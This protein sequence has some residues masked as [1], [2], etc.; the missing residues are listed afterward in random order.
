MNFWRLINKKS[1]HFNSIPSPPEI[2]LKVSSSFG[3][4]VPI[5]HFS[6]H[7]FPPQ[8]LRNFQSTNH[9]TVKRPPSVSRRPKCWMP[10]KP[11]PLFRQKLSG[12]CSCP[13]GPISSLQEL[14]VPPGGRA[15]SVKCDCCHFRHFEE[16]ACGERVGCGGLHLFAIVFKVPGAFL[17]AAFH[18]GI[19][20]RLMAVAADHHHH[21]HN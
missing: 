12:G 1:F 18:A 13:P 5:A 19:N 15:A 20:F 6:S 3:S 9:S 10:E 8:I 4:K 16:V 7:S 21:H 17:G 11:S 14:C 2:E